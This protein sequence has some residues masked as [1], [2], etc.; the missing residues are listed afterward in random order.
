MPD[1]GL[2]LST[3]RCVGALELSGELQVQ[4]CMKDSEVVKVNVAHVH[5]FMFF[6][7]KA[8]EVLLGQDK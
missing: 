4:T 3:V 2:Q 5:F 7:I 1:P 8:E 6:G